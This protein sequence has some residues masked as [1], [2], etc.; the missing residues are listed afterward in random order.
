M[1]RRKPRTQADR[2]ALL[3]SAP[4]FSDFDDAALSSLAEVARSVHL[5]PREE[6]FRKGEPGSQVYL[7]VEG[8]VKVMTTSRD[9]DD[10]VFGL[11]RPGEV[12]GE[13]AVLS[14]GARTATVAGVEPAELLVLDR[15]DFLP[16][17]RAHPDAAL[18]L[19]EQLAES[20]R[21][22]SEFVEDRLFLGLAPRLAKKLTEL[23]EKHG[24]T[25]EEGIRIDL[26]L[27]QTELGDLVGTT[28]ESINKQIQ[29]WRKQELVRF[30]R[31]TLTLLDPE[32][33]ER[34]AAMAGS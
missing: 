26:H 20:L 29:L 3:G 32:E 6:L 27:N 28:R 1:P 10:V 16:V 8:C 24:K 5:E 4:L 23:R 22:L 31:E 14:G 21:R 7:L 34:L 18:K 25:T 17:L 13:L 33:I 9:G 30:E 19:L 2:K 11:M 12:L 15:R